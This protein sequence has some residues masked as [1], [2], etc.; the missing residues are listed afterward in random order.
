[1]GEIDIWSVTQNGAWL[2]TQLCER[3]NF[4]IGNWLDR[5]ILI[6]D[7]HRIRY[8]QFILI[9]STAIYGLFKTFYGLQINK[10]RYKTGLRAYFKD[11]QKCHLSVKSQKKMYKSTD[12][13]TNHQMHTMRNCA[14]LPIDHKCDPKLPDRHSR[15]LF[16]C[17]FW[18]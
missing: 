4:K 9:V 15:P 17:D 5:V 13:Y 11:M 12:T 16:S 10:K 7:Y 2:S 8:N 1:M 6:H 18:G 14:F 3:Q